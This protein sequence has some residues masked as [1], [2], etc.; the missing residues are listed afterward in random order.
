MEFYWVPTRRWIPHHTLQ[1]LPRLTFTKSCET[2]VFQ[3][4]VY[5]CDKLSLERPSNVPKTIKLV[6][7]VDGIGNLTPD[8]ELFS[9]IFYYPLPSFRAHRCL[10]STIF[11]FCDL[12]W[13]DFTL[14]CGKVCRDYYRVSSFKWTT[15]YFSCVNRW[16]QPGNLSWN[17]WFLTFS[18]SLQV[19]ENCCNNSVCIFHKF[20]LYQL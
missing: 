18:P 2:N 15:R 10:E 17:S 5:R 8:P 14:P 4:L 6:R 1:I 12:G 7:G 13:W 9:S 16:I 3:C 19:Y 20:L 11:S